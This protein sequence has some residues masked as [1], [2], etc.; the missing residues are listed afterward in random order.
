MKHR[1]NKVVLAT[2]VCLIVFTAV[3][4]GVLIKYFGGSKDPYYF[5][6][7]KDSIELELFDSKAVS[8]THIRAKETP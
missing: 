7:A 6:F 3:V 1:V 8:Y 2:V 4:V 5:Y